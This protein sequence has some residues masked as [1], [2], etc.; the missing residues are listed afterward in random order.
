MLRKL[1]AFSLVPAIVHFLVVLAYANGIGGARVGDIFNVIGQPGTFVARE[2]GFGSFGF[3][4]ELGGNKIGLW[5]VM[6]LNSLL[7]GAVIGWIFQKLK[8]KS[9]A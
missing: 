6:V 7:W 3:F 9:G 2:L 8:S 1:T 5:A 4:G